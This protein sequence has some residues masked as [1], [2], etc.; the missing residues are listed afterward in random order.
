M[1]G[2]VGGGDGVPVDSVNIGEKYLA[3]ACHEQFVMQRTR[4][5]DIV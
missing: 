3:M 1:K 5:L 4:R 2:Q